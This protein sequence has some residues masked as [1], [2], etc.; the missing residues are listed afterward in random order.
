MITTMKRE[1]G[2]RVGGGEWGWGM[3]EGGGGGSLSLSLMVDRG[4]S[5]KG[6]RDESIKA[7]ITM[8]RPL[9][10]ADDRMIDK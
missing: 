3:G 1:G 8:T 5:Y 2:V 9:K 6:K 4:K 7:Q 10:E